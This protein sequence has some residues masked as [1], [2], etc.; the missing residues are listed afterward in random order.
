[1][2]LVTNSAKQVSGRYQINLPLRNKELNTPNNKKVVE[3]RA[4]Y[5]K[6]RLQKDSSFNAEYIAIMNDLVTKGYAETV[7]SLPPGDCQ[8]A[9]VYA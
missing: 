8:E 7:S 6:R 2:E 4:S 5:L 1:M 9:D 3:Q